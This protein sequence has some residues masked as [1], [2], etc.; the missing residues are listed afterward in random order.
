MR[1]YRKFCQRGPTE[2]NWINSDNVF[3]FL[4]RTDDGPT[5]NA[6]IVAL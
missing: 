1:G 5:L 6:G 2:L 3:F 4:W